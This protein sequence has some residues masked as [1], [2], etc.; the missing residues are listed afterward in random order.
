[1][2]WHFEFYGSIEFWAAVA[3][4]AVLVRTAGGSATTK[5]LVLLASSSALLLAIPR[6]GIVD[7]LEVWAIAAFSFAA[8]RLLTRP[9]LSPRRRKLTAV[10]GIAAV[11]A[12]LAFFKYR[13]IEDL[14]L[15]RPSGVRTPSDMLFLLGVSYFSFKALHVVVEAYKG[16]I[17]EVAALDYLNYFTFFPSFISGPISRY[18]QFVAQLGPAAR[19][20]LKR[21]LLLAGERIVH[22]LFKKLVL[23]RLML[24]YSLL[25]RPVE[26]LSRGQ[27]ALGLYATA[28]YF[29]FDFA[30]YSDLAIG[31]ARL[32]GMELPENFD[33]PFF[34]R[35]IRDLWTHWHMTLTSWLVDYVYWPLV[36]RL[37][38][39]DL[40]RPR[41]VLLSTVAMTLTFIACGMW[42]GETVNF[43]VWGAC[44][45]LGISAVTVYQRRKRAIPVPALQRYFRSRTSAV[46]GAIGT[47]H[48]FAALLTLFLFDLTQIRGLFAALVR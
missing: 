19:G 35:N 9:D 2:T 18:P 41:P 30:G 25:G 46:L 38:N 26:T 14:F 45:G 5:G 4:V 7:L 42:H 13:F 3:A 16:S 21:D 36:R 43:L 31:A 27:I 44:H 39:V 40:F 32:L 6:F 33:K 24:P 37:R 28:L 48:F 8:A 11:V 15:P 12:A 1:M 23:A 34:R 22:G 29:Y 47:F 10:I 17:R 20:G